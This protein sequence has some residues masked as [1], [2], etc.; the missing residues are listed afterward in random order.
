MVFSSLIFIFFFLPVTMTV[1]YISPRFLRNL[2]LFTASLL[3]YAWGEPVYIFMMLFTI[4]VNYAASLAIA[5]YREQKRIACA[6]FITTMAVDLGILCFFKY[7]G[8]LVDNLNVLFG[9]ELIA[10]ALPLPL[11]ISFYTFQTM[12]YVID[13]YREKTDVQRNIISFGTYITMFPQ[14]VAGPIVKYSDI[15]QQLTRRREN[16]SLFGE[17]AALFITGLAKKVLLANNIG[18]L[19]H[20]VKA[21]PIGELSVLSAWLGI[22]AFT[23]QIYFD[24]SGYS[25]MA[26]GLGKMFGFNLLKNFDYPYISTSITEFWHRWHISLGSWFR[27]YVYIPLGGNKAGRLNQYRNLLVVWFLTGLWHGA[28]WNFVLWGLYYGVFVTIEKLFL[29]EWL[30]RRPRFVGHLYTLF[31]VVIGWVL[32]EFE[33]IPQIAGYL[34]TMFGLG[35]HAFFDSQAVYY[36]YT[37]GALLLVLAVCSTPLVR[38]AGS[39]IQMKLGKAGLL[40]IP[41]IYLSLVFLSTAY[42]VN[43]SYN[44]FLYFRF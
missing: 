15:A 9:L 23:F 10:S 37:N 41:M 25:D 5:K 3:F 28:S 27:E 18:I 17:G 31:V 30:N 24:F 32:F 26:L 43:E 6:V 4:V 14:L 34:G 39:V 40:V 35:A 21:G 33:S 22:I 2:V 29:L 19:W 1:Y 36:L 38:K 8:F 44:P 11:G 13:V 12:S 20:S 42:L 16:L 7:Y